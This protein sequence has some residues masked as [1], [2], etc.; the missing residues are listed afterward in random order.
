M[1]RLMGEKDAAEAFREK[2]EKL[3]TEFAD[4]WWNAEEKCFFTYRMADGTF[5]NRHSGVNA[6]F[7]LIREVL[8]KPEQIEGQLDYIIANEKRLNVEDR[9]YLPALL[10]KYGR[11]EAAMDIWLR[12]TAPS[13]ERREY[14]EVSFAAVD[15]LITGYMGLE[16]DAGVN[17]VHTCSAVEQGDWALC[18]EIPLWGGSIDLKHEGKKASE[19]ANRTGRTLIWQ[20]HF[21][22]QTK[23]V[24]VQPGDRARVEGTGL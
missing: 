8:R 12:M 23:T 17:T 20:A 15:A 3:P 19:L 11:A 13:Y 6:A 1:Y 22:S 16:A 9:S 14:P 5:D 21:G 18:K 2:A 4:G 10:W 24:R 7:P